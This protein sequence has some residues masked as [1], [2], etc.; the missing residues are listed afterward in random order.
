MRDSQAAQSQSP[1]SLTPCTVLLLLPMM[2]PS[3]FGVLP[4]TLA[5][6]QNFLLSFLQRQGEGYAR[7]LADF[8]I[9]LS[10]SIRL[11]NS[12]F[13]KSTR[14]QP[15]KLSFFF[16][17]S[18]K[19]DSALLGEVSNLRLGSSGERICQRPRRYFLFRIAP[20]RAWLA[21][22]VV[23]QRIFLPFSLFL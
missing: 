18:A 22:F 14:S 13:S 15:T 19:Q 23:F 10:P 20:G 17:A 9:L 12:E 11:S 5:C 3:E 2:R 6:Q 16:S 7:L 4:K 21:D 1:L 8:V